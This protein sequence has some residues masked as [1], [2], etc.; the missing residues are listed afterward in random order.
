MYI[1]RVS[2]GTVVVSQFELY[3]ACTLRFSLTPIAGFSQHSQGVYPV[4]DE[5]PQHWTRAASTIAG[6][7]YVSS[8]LWSVVCL[9]STLLEFGAASPTG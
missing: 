4:D 7:R 3:T 9:P 8:R 6:P 5:N 2:Q 1:L